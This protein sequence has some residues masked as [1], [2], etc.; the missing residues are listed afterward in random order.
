MI[1][2][3]SDEIKKMERIGSGNFGSVYL[4]DDKVYKIYHDKI[5]AISV[6]FN[7]RE[8]INNPTLKTK[9]I[10]YEYLKY[11]NSK[12][13]YTDLIDDVLYV[14]GSFGGVVMPYYD[15]D[16]FEKYKNDPIEKKVSMAR[17]LLLNAKELTDNLIYP[18]D[19]K[20]NNIMLYENKIQIIDL[21][22][23]KTKVLNPIYKTE[24]IKILDDAIKYFLGDI[25]Y[26]YQNMKDLIEKEI[27]KTNKTYLAI[28]NYL[29]EI[30]KTHNYILIDEEADFKK[31]IDLLRKSNYRVV[32]IYDN[33][34]NYNN[35]EKLL[36]LG[37]RIYYILPKR[38]IDDYLSSIAY[39]ELL[40]VKEKEIVKIKK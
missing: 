40:T 22:D 13:K 14:D 32:Y 12:L 37:I 36:S 18:L 38:Y 11:I 39:D 16:T 26:N 6:T 15:G 25:N 28:E 5:K 8:I 2:I 17:Q 27:N 3:S 21:D 29:S 7:T 35:L 20:S 33:V 1:N 19:Y 23:V 9:P 10:K 4:K 31:Y 24:S 34:C 30:I